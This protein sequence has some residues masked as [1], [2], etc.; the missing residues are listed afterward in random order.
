[1]IVRLLWV[2]A[3]V[4]CGAARAAGQGTVP[5]A[6]TASQASSTAGNQTAV[7]WSFS[8]A[9]YT[10]LVP[11]DGN[12]AQ[13]TFTVDRGWLHLE[14]RLNYEDLDTGSAWIGYNFEGGENVQWSLT[15]MLGGV[16]GN[17]SGGAP[18]YKGGLNWWK[19]GFWSEG[20]YVFDADD[21]SESF[22]Y[23]WSELTLS[24]VEWWRVGLVTQRT[25]VYATDRDV[26]RG[27]LVGF[28]FRNID[29]AVYLFNPDDSKPITVLAVTV[30]F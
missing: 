12:Y 22:F 23:N 8:A 24:A 28:T 25:R 11:D 27:L 20:E 15:P 10:Y 30:G 9:A 16:F 2:L 5:G 19:L 17:T 21:S 13:P 14:G 7:E 29:S 3:I 26:Q 18:G 6:P 4:V 1:M